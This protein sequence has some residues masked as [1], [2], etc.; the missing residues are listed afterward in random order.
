[1]IYRMSLWIAKHDGTVIFHRSVLEQS[2]D[3]PEMAQDLVRAE[4]CIKGYTDDKWQATHPQVP[5]TCVY[6]F[7]P[8]GV[9]WR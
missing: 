5:S 7:G 9:S 6:H 4:F 3:T 2:A 1:M 8:V